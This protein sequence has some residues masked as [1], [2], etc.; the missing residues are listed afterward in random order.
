MAKNQNT[1]IEWLKHFRNISIKV[2]GKKNLQRKTN[3]LINEIKFSDFCRWLE[4][5]NNSR[6]LTYI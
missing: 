2:A 4:E 3:M 1:N 6:F 5:I